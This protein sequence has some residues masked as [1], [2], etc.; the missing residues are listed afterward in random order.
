M[1]LEDISGK[2]VALIFPG[3]GSQTVGMGKELCERSDVARETFNAADDLL[4]FSLSTLCFEGPADELEDTWNAQPALLTMSVA[5][6]RELG[7]IYL[8]EI[9]QPPGLDSP[10]VPE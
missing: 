5:A 7:Q 1:A 3:Q 10:L 9:A 6:L 8:V 4:G 2:R